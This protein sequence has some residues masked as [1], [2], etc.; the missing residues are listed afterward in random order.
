VYCFLLHWNWQAME[1]G[2]RK[3]ARRSQAQRSAN[4]SARLIDATINCLYEKG[5]SATS[6]PLVAKIAGVS[7]GAMLHHFATKVALMAAT[8]HA[9]YVSDIAAYTIALSDIKPGENRVDK[10]ID[11]AWECFKSPN[12]V[13]QTEIW[14][15]TRSDPELAAAVL[16]IHDAIGKRS[17]RALSF[18][19]DHYQHK[20]EVFMEGLLCYLVSALRGLALQHVLG[21]PPKELALGVSLI[22][23]TVHSMLVDETD[24]RAQTL[25]QAHDML[26]SIALDQ[27]A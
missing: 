7:R 16:P 11:T 6:T 12:G 14:M 13:A 23:A 25:G 18:V 15:A 22:K 21:S 20:Q 3:P 1:Q 17:V 8:V 26:S 19:M 2:S 9:T 27:S 24:T 10:L 4:T 5:Y